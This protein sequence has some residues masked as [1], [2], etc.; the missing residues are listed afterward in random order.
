M[1][2]PSVVVVLAVWLAL[3]PGLV[4]AQSNEPDLA[5]GIRQVEDGDYSAA[6]ITLDRAA[7]AVENQKERAHELARAYLYLGIA[8]V[9]LGSETSARARFRDALAQSRDLR[10]DPE[11]FPP[12][13]I[14]L[15][16]KAREENRVPAPNAASPAPTSAPASGGKK[17]SKTPLILIGLGGAAAAG[18]AVA[19]GG[20]GGGT[21]STSATV[22]ATAPA[23]NKTETF[24]GSISDGCNSDTVTYR[25]VP[26]AAGTLEATLAW[27]DRDHP[28]TM[29]LGDT[30]RSEAATLARSSPSSN[31]S[32]R[33]SA[34]VQ[35]KTYYVFVEQAG[36]GPCVMFTLTL[37][38]PQ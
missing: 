2:K 34:A 36:G 32:A 8:Y 25:F 11:Q 7:R 24:N 16:E 27:T 3:G 23:A 10:L 29:L 30:D 15:F 37:T 19:A 26:N 28:I 18:V 35:N 1:S 5:A 6:V 13:V 33:M 22:P 17:K 20:G 4:A 9:G 12:K 14:E 38:Y 31:T 21:A